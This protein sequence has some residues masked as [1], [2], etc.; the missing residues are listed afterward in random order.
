MPL[1]FVLYKITPIDINKT[2]WNDEANLFIT[3]IRYATIRFAL[4]RA[5]LSE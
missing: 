3:C 2:L 5:L 1:K 4:D